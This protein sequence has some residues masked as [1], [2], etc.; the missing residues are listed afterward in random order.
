MKKLSTVKN[1]FIPFLFILFIST[2]NSQWNSNFGGIA[3]GDINYSSAK[4]NAVTTD[5]YGN[6]YVTGRSYEGLGNGNDIVII[7]YNPEGVIQ[8][9]TGYNGSASGNDEGMG[10]CVDGEN[11]VYI[12]GQAKNDT[13]GDDL[14]LIKYSSLGVQLWERVYY[15]DLDT[16]TDIG[17][18]IAVDNLNNIYVTG[19]ATG[20]DGLMDVV[21]LKYSK[22]GNLLWDKLYDG[23]YDLNSS[24]N[25]I[26]VGPT[27]KVY[28]TGYTTFPGKAE[29]IILICY[30]AT[31]TQEWVKRI[32][33]NGNSEDKAWGIVV[34]ETGD[35]IYISGWITETDGGMNALT[36]KF[37][38]AGVRLWAVPYNG[39]GNQTDKA[40]GIVVDTDGNVY[41]TGETTDE[42]DNINYLTLSYNSNG[43]LRWNVFYNGTGNGED[44]ASAIGLIRNFDFSYSIIVTGKSW[45]DYDNFDYATVRYDASTGYQEAVNRYSMSGISDDVSKDVAVS[46]DGVVFITG[47]SQLIIEAHNDVSYIS[48]QKMVFGERSELIGNN[49]TPGK[50]A[51]YQN[52]PNPFNPSTS[53]RFDVANSVDVKLVVYDILGKVAAVLVNQKL[54]AGTYNISYSNQ[55]LSSGI[56]F[57][58]LKAGNFRDVKKMSLI[59]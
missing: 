10:I 58:E 25:S 48:T 55:D 27:G 17:L 36:A 7:K 3:E 37:S 11:N 1:L 45:G 46:D 52:Y 59:K 4:G 6:S 57:Y 8:W 31:G 20:T 22:G 32:S 18:D 24:G 23:Y 19:Y 2:V 41:T 49:N 39:G 34:D 9:A 21:T 54:S 50:F 13:T 38:S 26:A 53:I 35:Y 56:Y 12:V 14:V 28:V 51:L 47:Y 29:E 15:R 16:R 44:I 43:F 42:N 5:S 33:G 30:S 40:W